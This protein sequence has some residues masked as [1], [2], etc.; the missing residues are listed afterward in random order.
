MHHRLRQPKNGELSEEKLRFILSGVNEWLKFAEAKLGVLVAINGSVA[1]AALSLLNE[2]SQAGICTRTAL[3]LLALTNVISMMLCLASLAPC[4]SPVRCADGHGTRATVNLLYF[5]D[6]A[7][8]EPKDYLASM[9]T[10]RFER[11]RNSSGADLMDYAEQIV[12]NS[13]IA[14]KKYRF[15]K[16]GVIITII[17]LT[18]VSLADIVHLV[19]MLFGAR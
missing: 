17:G 11:P 3:L 15:F 1:F 10:D 12:T 2:Q 7:A 13:R 16:A 4:Q 9:A 14:V 5:E 8:L 18:I 19:L 6:I